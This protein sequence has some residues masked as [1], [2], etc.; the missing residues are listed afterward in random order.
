MK[1]S[2]YLKLYVYIDFE[3]SI[4]HISEKR[5][6]PSAGIPLKVE[7]CCFSATPISLLAYMRAKALQIG[8]GVGRF[9]C[10]RGDRPSMHQRADLWA[11]GVI[12]SG[13]AA[14]SKYL[15]KGSTSWAF[16]LM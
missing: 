3:T 15:L 8:S 2:Q 12:C 11:W 1:N 10:G 6:F 14:Q 4:C 5:D 13:L 7:L 16:G 9:G